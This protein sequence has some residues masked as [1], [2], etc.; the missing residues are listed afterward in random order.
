MLYFFCGLQVRKSSLFF[1][2]VLA[3]VSFNIAYG[4]K[5]NPS[6]EVI[7]ESS[8]F[9][10]VNNLGGSLDIDGR[11][12]VA[13]GVDSDTNHVAVIFDRHLGGPDVWNPQAIIKLPNNE[14]I[15]DVSINGD[16]VVLSFSSDDSYGVDAGSVNIYY[17]NYPTANEWGLLKTIYTPASPATNRFGWKIDV[18]GVYLAVSSANDDT[19]YLFKRNTGGSDNW[20]EVK[21]ITQGT[22]KK[23]SVS[24][25]NGLLVI[26]SYV[27]KIAYVYAQNNGGADNW[28]EVAQLTRSDTSSY[29]LFGYDVAVWGETAVIGAYGDAD[30]GGYAGAAYIY[31]RNNGGADNWGEVKKLVANDAVAGQNF[32]RSVAIWNDTIM[33]SADGDTETALGGAAY[34]YTRNK[35]GADNWG[36][37]S[38]L[39]STNAHNLS[40]PLLRGVAVESDFGAAAVQDYSSLSNEVNGVRIFQEYPCY[41]WDDFDNAVILTDSNSAPL[42]DFGVT[43]SLYGD[44][45]AVG[46]GTSTNA[47]GFAYIYERNKGAK[48]TWG[49]VMKT[50]TDVPASMF[51]AEVSLYGDTLAVAAPHGFDLNYGLGKTGYVRIFERNSGGSDAWGMSAYIAPTNG[52]PL[53][54]FGDAIELDHDWLFVG[55]PDDDH[56][57][58]NDGAVHIYNRN[59][60][61]AGF[62]GEVKMVLPTNQTGYHQFGSALSADNG[63]I[64]IGDHGEINSGNLAEGTVY[65]LEQNAGGSN[66]WGFVHTIR[67]V[68]P[69]NSAYA[70]F[71]NAL[72]LDGDTLA[73]GAPPYDEPLPDAGAVYVFERNRGGD[74]EWG[75][76]K[77][78]LPDDSLAEN[79]GDFGKSV[80][81]FGDILAV[82]MPFGTND[83]IFVYG[84]NE[85]GENNW[86]LLYTYSGS[87]GTG[88]D[89][90]RSVSLFGQR[91]AMGEPKKVLG[92]VHILEPACNRVTTHDDVVA[93]DGKT[94]LR[95]AI[96][97][98]NACTNEEMTI[99]LADGDYQLSLVGSN[100]N[101]NATGDLDITNTTCAITIRGQGARKTRILGNDDRIFDIFNSTVELYGLSLVDGK[102]PDGLPGFGGGNGTSGESGGA[103]RNYGNLTVNHCTLNNNT[104]GNGGDAQG[105]QGTS[106]GQGGNGGAVFN[107]GVLNV[108]ASLF[109]KNAAGDG[110][111]GDNTGTHGGGGAIFNGSGGE[112]LAVNSTFSQNTAG[113]GFGTLETGGD[114]GAI[115]IDSGAVFARLR[116]N[117]FYDNKAGRLFHITGKGGAVY[118]GITI[119]PFNYNLLRFNEGDA[120]PSVFATVLNPKYNIMDDT[121]GLTIVGTSSSNLISTASISY[122]ANNYGP[123][124][125]CMLFSNNPGIDFIPATLGGIPTYDQRGVLR[126]TNGVSVDAGAVEY[127]GKDFDGDGYSDIYEQEYNMDP[128]TATYLPEDSDNDGMQPESEYVAFTDWNNSSS[129]LEIVQIGQQTNSFSVSF[130]SSSH[131]DYTLQKVMAPGTG[132]WQDVAGNISIQGSNTVITLTDTNSI[133]QLFYRIKVDPP[134]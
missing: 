41:A 5:L 56:A 117:T 114:G 109:D 45:V 90:G 60:D 122:P 14:D 81:L 102:A 86:G 49:L 112:L 18:D 93:N 77:Q 99:Y 7:V 66:N 40:T 121:N 64:A 97:L 31:S 27:D 88:R 52:A 124:D 115:Y 133:S 79:G 36:Q 20:G 15:T 75:Q 82:G 98:A 54:L 28:G 104:A 62:W 44:R 110:G 67:V 108:Y 107:T 92:R 13:K 89:A 68:A 57:G 42:S 91:I 113:E 32:G 53:D 73:V 126:P 39:I 1:G 106:G 111:S 33:V 74:G 43:V 94:S 78:L 71:G 123:T 55:A 85:G 119:D 3:F 132:I 12:L 16:I 6:R 29:A 11:T 101:N 19:V 17:R 58:S 50:A 65:I 21:Y 48:D 34:I 125:T 47:D 2:L 10:L 134:L 61:G 76:V 128:E 127:T 130:H 9:A 120:D 51:G 37:S 22:L 46:S 23:A 35:G 72:S 38:K 69:T 95:E 80:S 129:V 131:R 70:H 118:S 84:R 24:L 83:M 26:G 87:L 25:H 4:S 105:G 59:Q 103:I 96:N 63:R 100:E 116:F 30:G 8:R